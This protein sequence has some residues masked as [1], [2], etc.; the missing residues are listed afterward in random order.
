MYKR[1]G[2]RGTILVLGYTPPSEARTL[3]FW[4]ITQTVADEAHAAA[5]EATGVPL[6]VHIALDT[7]MHRLGIPWERRRALKRILRSRTLRVRCV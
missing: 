3:R 5:L 6:H 7:G 2:I 1:Q 4:R